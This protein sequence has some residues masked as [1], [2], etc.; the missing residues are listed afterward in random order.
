[1]LAKLRLKVRAQGMTSTLL[2]FLSV[3]SRCVRAAAPEFCALAKEND[4][5]QLLDKNY[6]TDLHPLQI[7]VIANHGSRVQS[8]PKY[9]SKF[10]EV[11]WN[12][13]VVSDAYP[14]LDENH[15][16]FTQPA[17][18][19]TYRKVYDR[20]RSILPG[21]CQLGQLTDEGF[22]QQVNNGRELRK[23]Y[24][25]NK[26]VLNGEYK[27][28]WK[29]DQ[30]RKQTYENFFY[31]RSTDEQHSIMS[32]QILF[33]S[34]FVVDKNPG[35]DQL[36]TPWHTRDSLAETL[37]PNLDMCPRLRNA[38]D[39]AMASDGY[40]AIEKQ[41]SALKI[42]K[43]LHGVLGAQ[44]D[45]MN[46]DLG[47]YLIASRCSHHRLPPALTPEL[48]NRAMHLIQDLN[49][50]VMR[51]NSSFYSKLAMRPFFQDVWNQIKMAI[52][53]DTYA[54]K[55]VLYSGDAET[56]M[57]FLAA[58]GGAVWDGK[59]APDAA[60]LVIELYQMDIPSPTSP[61]GWMHAF[62]LLYQ[63]R[64]LIVPGCTNE[65]C[66]VHVLRKF[67]ESLGSL[68]S[69]YAE[70]IVVKKKQDEIAASCAGCG[71]DDSASS[72]QYSTNGTASLIAQL[73]DCNQ[74]ASTPPPAERAESS[75]ATWTNGSVGMIS[76]VSLLIGAL[77]STKCFKAQYQYDIQPDYGVPS[78]RSA[79]PVSMQSYGY[80]T[81]TYQSAQATNNCL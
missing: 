57:P 13:S 61:S 27:K 68:G 10:R 30:L 33:D 59:W 47:K 65:V 48:V 49:A 39:A 18:L 20:D 43:F 42:H 38:R 67:V 12:C 5:I 51:Y 58:F 64:P 55:F 74:K 77:L 6:L 70:H 2:L 9:L 14:V 24:V 73:A 1:M 37:R 44:F 79:V 53:G 15:G 62:R 72:Q 80:Q 54:K 31:L 45:G 69:C 16:L 8:T 3:A 81:Q 19:R 76:L 46:A 21:N 4:H 56:I 41:A 28:I 11:S 34:L 60:L 32:G 52:S 75:S 36:I 63:G 71:S 7:Q 25:G 50:Y 35:D 29:D 78:G 66:D 26:A 22:A 40:K 23:A 17:T